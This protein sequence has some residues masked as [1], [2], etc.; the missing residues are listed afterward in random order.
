MTC[1]TC[2]GDHSHQL[3]DF[4]KGSSVIVLNDFIGGIDISLYDPFVHTQETAPRVTIPAGSK[5]RVIGHCD[6]GRALI[7][8]EAEKGKTVS[9][10]SFHYPEGYFISARKLE[11]LHAA[12]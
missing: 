6:D 4:P 12:V 5:G 2:G 3:T 8:F 7:E 10:H 1:L 9:S 11:A